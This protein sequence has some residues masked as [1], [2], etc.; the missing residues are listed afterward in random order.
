I[1]G[2][3]SRLFNVIQSGS[4]TDT[5]TNFIVRNRIFDKVLIRSGHVCILD[6]DM[7]N[8]KDKNGNLQYPPQDGL[9]FLPGNHPPEKVLCDLYEKSHKDASLRYHIDDSNVHCLF[10][11]M[12]ELGHAA[13]E[14]EA[15]NACWGVFV[16]TR[17]K[18][19]NGLVKFLLAESRRYSP[20]L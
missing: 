12:I 14:D 5:Y 9:F 11:K 6:G 4:A 20:D 1:P 10:K 17:K 2:I 8:E 18:E 3:S 16:S 15:F 19:F 13:N 7:R